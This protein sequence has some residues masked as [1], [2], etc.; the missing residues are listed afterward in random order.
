MRWRPAAG[1]PPRIVV[2][3][4]L[5]PAGML[6]VSVTDNGPGVDP[7]LAT[8]IFRPFFTTKARGTGLGLALVQKI[9]VTHNGRVSAANAE[10]GGAC[11]TVALPL[12]AATAA[13]TVRSVPELHNPGLTLRAQ[14]RR[15]LPN[16]SRRISHL[17]EAPQRDS[18]RGNP[19]AQQGSS[20][21]SAL[22]TT[23][24]SR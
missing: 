18:V 4:T 15:F 24:G 2:E 7:A 8:R 23:A 22:G 11:L 9:I 6:R 3:G 21:I 20:C 14:N 16:K 12:R 13:R 19:I 10:G 5:D 1:D 17:T